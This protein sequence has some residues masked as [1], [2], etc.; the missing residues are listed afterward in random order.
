MK[1]G[2]MSI[3]PIFKNLIKSSKF[4]KISRKIFS[5]ITALIFL[6][7]ISIFAQPVNELKIM[8]EEYPPYN[9]KSE[10]LAKG[11]AVDMMV[12][13]LQK[14][15]STQKRENIIFFPWARGYNETLQVPNTCLFSTTRTEEREDLFKWVGP[16]G[17]NKLVLTARKDRHIKIDSF[18]DLKKYKIGVIFEDVAEQVLIEK[19]INKEDLES[20]SKTVHNIKK[21][22]SERIDL[23]GYGE[24]TAKWE[25]KKQGFEPN[26]Y[27][28]VYIIQSKDLYFAFY[29]ETDDALIN[30][31]QKAL[32]E[33]KEAGE[34]QKVLDHYLN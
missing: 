28:T 3:K 9:F 20:V 24:D 2:T 6:I 1:R 22:N 30:Q 29:K 13:V 14:M 16:V 25:I 11:I 26:D 33:L 32:D 27:E 34:Y 31:F 8:T 4:N 15:G 21:L 5:L 10:N 19:G 23:W 12:Q 7:P 18:E 17:I